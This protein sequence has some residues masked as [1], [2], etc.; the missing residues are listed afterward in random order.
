MDGIEIWGL[1][2]SIQWKRLK[3]KTDGI[4]K[5]IG[6]KRVRAVKYQKG[7]TLSLAKICQAFTLVLVFKRYLL[8]HS[9]HSF[10]VFGSQKSQY[11]NDMFVGMQLL[12]YV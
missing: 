8:N 1:S 10:G 2:P 4:M 9:M 12:I 5:L 3:K 7:Y 6:N 11:L